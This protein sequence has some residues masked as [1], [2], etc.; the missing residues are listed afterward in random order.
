MWSPACGKWLDSEE[1]HNKLSDQSQRCRPLQ[2][3]RQG[4]VRAE[5]KILVD[6]ISQTI[7]SRERTGLDS[8]ECTQ[9]RDLW[10][11]PNKITVGIPTLNSKG[12]R[13]G[14]NFRSKCKISQYSL[15][16]AV[17]KSAV[18]NRFLHRQFNYKRRLTWNT[19]KNNFHVD[20]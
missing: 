15:S 4:T 14:G 1:L 16:S 8:Q 2:I 10:R 18:L 9:E 19:L 11:S 17:S 6:G 3:I 20:F 7:C 5:V 12:V 13:S